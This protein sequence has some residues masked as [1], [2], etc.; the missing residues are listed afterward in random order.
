ME[1]EIWKSIKGYEGLYEVSNLG[2]VKSLSRLTYNGK[3][4]FKTKERPIKTQLG[5]HGYL[6]STLYKENTRETVGVHILVACA[7]LNHIPNGY[8]IV[9][10][11]IN[12]IKTDPRAVNLR[13]VTQRFNLTVGVRKDRK[14]FS[15][16][17]A[18][19]CRYKDKNKWRAKIVIEGKQKHLGYFSNEIEAHN[20]YQKELNN[21][22]K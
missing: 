15:S 17:Y 20:A 2:N 22:S 4:E 7:F 16:Q 21:L 3:G 10:D 18:G 11:H 9:V 19:V 13:L 12:G 6:F 5:W 8:E 14:R 1:E